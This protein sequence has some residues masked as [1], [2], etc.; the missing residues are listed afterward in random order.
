MNRLYRDRAP[1]FDKPDGKQAVDTRRRIDWLI[2]LL[3]V[4]T[5][6][7]CFTVM[8]APAHASN[9]VDTVCSKFGDNAE[10]IVML[11]DRGVPLSSL[12][13]AA[14]ET[15]KGSALSAMKELTIQVYEQPWLDKTDARRL[16]ES[17]CYRSF[18]GV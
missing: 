2:L 11:R 16:I 10:R 6:S 13:Q 17:S 8:F 15:L 14:S 7:L 3:I 9:K 1:Q 5:V 4:I 18:R 12:M